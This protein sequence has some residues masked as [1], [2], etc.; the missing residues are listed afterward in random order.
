MQTL[1][2]LNQEVPLFVLQEYQLIQKQITQSHFSH[3]LFLRLMELFGQIM[4][5]THF[6]LHKDDNNVL[7]QLYAYFTRNDSLCTFYDIDPNK[8]L[9]L[10]GK[11][12]VGKTVHMKLIR[13]FLT[14]KTR[15][16]LKTCHSLALEYMNN[17]S[18]T[19]MYYG[20][21]Y[22]DYIDPYTI[23]QSYCFDD[24][25]TEDG[26]KHFG[27]QTNVMGQVILMR[28]D[29]FQNNKVKTHFTSNLTASQIEKFYGD[30]VRSRLRE[31]CNWIEYRN[32][33][34]KRK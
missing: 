29:L 6:K 18:E 30:R 31:M 32:A 21:N 23:H 11:T 1:R 24:L 19:I 16:R 22:V 8:G 7:L 9:F 34:D 15:F 33:F 28:Y 17:G 14:F 26:V 20:R 4:Y 10:S 13:Q 2:I 25:G 3:E 5:G 12:G 27:T